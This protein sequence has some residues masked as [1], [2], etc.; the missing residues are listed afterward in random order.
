[1]QNTETLR[2]A[3]ITV[4]AVSAPPAIPEASL[5]GANAG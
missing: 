1:M 3:P 5:A 4:E 2:P